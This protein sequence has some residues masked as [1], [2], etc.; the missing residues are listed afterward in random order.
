[1]PKCRLKSRRHKSDFA[2][3]EKIMKKILPLIIVLLS[4]LVHAQN[5]QFLPG[6]IAVLRAGDGM[7][8]QKLKQAPV[9]I[10]QFDPNSLNTAPSLTVPIPTNGANSFFFNGRAATEGLL[11]RSPDHRL[12]AFAGYGGVNLLEKSGTPALLDIPRGFSTVDANGTIHTYL[13]QAHD[14]SEKVNPRGVATDGAN[15]FWGCGNAGGTLYFNPADGKRTVQFQPFQNSRAAKIIGGVL[16]VTLNGPDGKAID[17]PAGIYRFTDSSGNPLPLPRQADTM[18]DL[19]VP[20]AEP[21]T[22]IAGFDLSPDKT[23][24]YTA[25]TV[26]GVQKYVKSGGGWKLACNFAIPQNIPAA[27]NHGTGC[28]GLAVDFSRP[29]PVIYATT[30]EGWDGSVN[31]NRVVRIVD[32]NATAVV[33]TLAQA[34]GDK[35]AFRGIDFT[36]EIGTVSAAKP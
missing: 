8:G 6:Q 10:D 11:T 20:A 3:G 34:P 5:V 13:Y 15:H 12:L 36:P 9:F 17:E 21:F 28:F 33:T 29:V 22:K 16:Y 19:V 24:A 23:I 4:G 25:D 32:T 2:N 26:A 35:I 27:E 7:V 1:L 30:T 14:A 31:S 18:I